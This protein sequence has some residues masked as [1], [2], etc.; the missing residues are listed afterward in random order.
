LN[1][2]I[3]LVIDL[4][5]T[6]IRT[7]LLIEAA[8][9]FGRSHPLTAWRMLSWLKEGK[10]NL[11]ERL[12]QYHD[13]D[14][15]HLPYNENVI[16]LI[17]KEREKGR[18]IILATASHRAYAQKIFDHLRI[19]DEILATDRDVNL[20][21]K[22][23][24]NRLVELFGNGGFDYVGNSHDDLP[25]WKAARKAYVIDP[26]GRLLS[27]A[28]KYN[29]DIEL[30]NT[31]NASLISWLKALRMHQWL[32][33]ILIFVPLAAS[34]Q[35]GN[36]AAVA[37]NAI[38]FIL[39]GLCASS[40]YILNDLFDLKDDRRHARKRSRAFASGKVSIRTGLLIF[41]LLLALSFAGSLWLLPPGFSAV[42][43]I[44][45]IITLA[46][47]L[48]LK[49]V[50]VADVIVLAMLY[51]IR[52]IAGAFAFDLRPSF[53][54]LAFSMFFF[55]SLAL[56]KRYAELMDARRAG[57]SSK[58]GGRGY[59][60]GD[61]EILAALG[62]AS[63]YLSVVVLAFYIQD[64]STISLY[65][66]PQVIWLACPVA[67]FW[68]S[69]IWVLTHRGAMHEDPVIFAIKDRVSWFVGIL[70]VAIFWAAV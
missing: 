57:K 62:A 7:D 37:C 25:I 21:G 70:C 59:Y 29:N 16:S 43:A 41:P 19:F 34:H 3:P 23:K 49:K 40:V 22:N 2:S 39:F 69:R 26:S 9:D 28:K 6:L 11:K 14:V 65:R 47:S 36:F 55:L 54:M 42:M 63:G 1:S 17:K 32:K 31:H 68:V 30:I 5:G 51:T 45:Y 15:E 66:F 56:V 44:Y 20:A 58:A 46:Y 10:A 64:P 67:L 4:D 53:W 52:I 48:G 38:A 18:K 61:L 12:T 60:P 27:K 33:N 8:L 24:R 50:V 13:I 35:M